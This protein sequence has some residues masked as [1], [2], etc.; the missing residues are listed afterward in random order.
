[1]KGRRGML[2][3]GDVARAINFLEEAQLE[4][5][6]RSLDRKVL[7]TVEKLNKFAKKFE[8]SCA[9]IVKS[10]GWDI[11]DVWGGLNRWYRENRKLPPRL[12]E[13]YYT[14]Y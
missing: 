13:I 9:K 1:M 7:E 6:S 10:Y 11:M 14:R 3:V 8:E 12:N 5:C 4:T 2:T